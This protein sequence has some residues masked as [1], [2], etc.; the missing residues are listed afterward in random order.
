MPEQPQKYGPPTPWDPRDPQQ[1]WMSAAPAPSQ[2]PSLIGKATSITPTSPWARGYEAATNLV[3][4]V[5]TVFKNMADFFVPAGVEAK[6]TQFLA[7]TAPT[8]YSQLLKTAKE[9]LPNWVTGEQA[10]ATLKGGAK[11]DEFARLNNRIGI[12]PSLKYS[13]E[14][15]VKRI[16]RAMPEFAD[17]FVKRPQASSYVEQP[18]GNKN[19]KEMFVTYSDD[20]A[21][22]E[23]LRKHEANIDDLNQQVYQQERLYE[24]WGKYYRDLEKGQIG[25]PTGT[26][27]LDDDAALYDW[28]RK[29]RPKQMEVGDEVDRLRGLLHDQLEKWSFLRNRMTPRWKDGHEFYDDV[30]NPIVRLRFND[31][32]GPNGEK[33]LFIE[34]MQPPHPDQQAKMPPEIAKRWREIGMKRALRLAAE[35]NYDKLAWTTGEM[36]AKRYSLGGVAHAIRYDRDKKIFQYVTPQ[37]TRFNWGVRNPNDP[38]GWAWD[39]LRIEPDKLSD[40]VGPDLAKNLLSRPNNEHIVIGEQP[41]GSMGLRRLYDKDLG[42]TAE[43]LGAKP[44]T[45]Q[46]EHPPYV[47]PPN[48][49]SITYNDVR[50]FARETG[51]DEEDAVDMFNCSMRGD[52]RDIP[53]QEAER[54][55]HEIELFDDALMTWMDA[56]RSVGR[57]MERKNVPGIQISPELREKA[58][59]KGF[60]MYA[61]DPMGAATWLAGSLLRKYNQQQE[62]R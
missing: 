40:W 48:Q 51:M 7:N 55:Q 12:E 35:G 16:E 43:K 23:A 13:K 28:M 27:D 31:R 52:D 44:S 4:Q 26:I 45:I 18:G 20:P 53:W 60:P 9:K 38:N 15:V 36:Q 34:E 30:D 14:D 49:Y 11:A 59:M 61:L 41:I 2:P 42:A 17:H 37:N 47:E 54:I 50:Q 46:I 24:D 33:I 6:T 57:P 32:T 1:A 8:F 21:A 58:L 62:K 39:K 10:Q 3:S 56:K 19:Y 29:A 25:G 5:P 22:S